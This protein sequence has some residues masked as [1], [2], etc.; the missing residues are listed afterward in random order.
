VIAAIALGGALGTKTLAD[1]QSGVGG[2]KSAD[3]ALEKG[4]A[5]GATEQ[6]LFQSR[7]A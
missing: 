7:G 4:F 3:L 5:H 2:S 6:V 1:S